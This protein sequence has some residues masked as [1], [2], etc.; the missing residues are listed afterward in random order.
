MPAVTLL[1][2]CILGRDTQCWEKKYLHP[3][4]LCVFC[5]G[6]QDIT[7]KLLVSVLISYTCLYS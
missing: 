3:S 1:V 7:F 2:Q 5:Y 4:C 6:N